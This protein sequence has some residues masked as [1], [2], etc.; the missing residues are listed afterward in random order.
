MSAPADGGVD[1]HAGISRQPRLPQTTASTPMSAPSDAPTTACPAPRRRPAMNVLTDADDQPIEVCLPPVVGNSVGQQA[2]L[3]ASA[4]RR[5]R[6][7]R[8]PRSNSALLAALPPGQR[9]MFRSLWR[10]TL[11]AFI[12][13][14][15]TQGDLLASDEKDLHHSMTAMEDYPGRHLE[16]M[17]EIDSENW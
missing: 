2:T 3:S 15:Q 9:D 16:L 10:A 5:K 6:R 7:K 13:T 17:D 1:V 12:Q 8:R 11:Q 4:A 14:R